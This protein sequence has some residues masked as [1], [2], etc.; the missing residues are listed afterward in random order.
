MLVFVGN[1]KFKYQISVQSKVVNYFRKKR[2]II[3]VSQGK[4]MSAAPDRFLYLFA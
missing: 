2:F 1:V 3:N 4:Y